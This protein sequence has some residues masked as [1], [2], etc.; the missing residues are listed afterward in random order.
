MY[1]VFI[2]VLACLMTGLAYLFMRRLSKDSQQKVQ[3]YIAQKLSDTDN[4][5][6][7][8]W[9]EVNEAQKR[10][11]EKQIIF[12]RKLRT[13]D[14]FLKKGLATEKRLQLEKTEWTKKKESENQALAEARRQLEEKILN[15]QEQSHDLE[16]SRKQIQDEE[17][18]LKQAE[19]LLAEK[20][21][22]L[23]SEIK[24]L[25]KD[26]R[27]TQEDSRKL[28][29]ERIYFQKQLK[30][31][32]AKSNHE[33][34]ENPE[35]EASV[36]GEKQ[37]N[38]SNKKA[39]QCSPKDTPYVSEPKSKTNPPK[40]PLIKRPPRRSPDPPEDRPKSIHEPKPEI[41]CQK[42]GGEWLVGVELPEDICTKSSMRLNQN[43][44]A[45]QQAENGD[46]FWYLRQADGQVVISWDEDGTNVKL[47]E[48]PYLF[49]KLSGQNQN[50][51]RLMR[52][53]SQGSYLLVVPESWRRNETLS[54]T[55][56]AEPEPVSLHGYQAHFFDIEKDSDIKIA[57]FTQNNEPVVI[58][59][60]A[61]DIE[62][63]GH[64]LKDAEEKRG[65]LFG[66]G[67]PV[68]R[69]LHEQVWKD[70]SIII[71]GEEGLG[72]GKG[73]TEMKPIPEKQEQELPLQLSPKK[74]GWYFLRFYDKSHELI[75]SMDFRFVRELHEIKVHQSSPVPLNYEYKPTTI[76]FSHEN[77]CVIKPNDTDKKNIAI[78]RNDTKTIVTIPAE[79]NWDKTR[80]LVCSK[81]KSKVPVTIL[82]ER[83]WWAISDE[84]SEP[85]EWSCKLLEIAR[86]DLAASSRKALWLRLPNT[87]WVKS[88][89]AGFEHTKAKQFPVKVAEQTVAMPFR[90]FSD[91]EELQS[92]GVKPF[93]VWFDHK[94]SE[95]T[96][97][98]A[99]LEV[100]LKCN[101]CDFLKENEEDF[102]DHVKSKHLDELIRPLSYEEMRSHF[103]TI[104]SGI[105]K[106]EY[107]LFYTES[108]DPNNPTSTVINHILVDCPEVPR[109]DGPVPISFS[110][111]YDVEEIKQNVKNKFIQEMQLYY[112]CTLCEDDLKNASKALRM[113]H[114]KNIHL[115]SLWDLH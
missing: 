58:S 109:G 54:G 55:A 34:P 112:K 19:R 23:M 33:P 29:E 9:R 59:P 86:N 37:K 13:L 50:Y 8:K 60:K 104:P 39:S 24:R 3:N 16:K 81:G 72:R 25:E 2:V 21:L 96:L 68:I 28:K 106:C 83:L 77:G 49:F 12:A 46:N 101:Y 80:W 85:S 110:P 69:A 41:V 38:S 113:E 67:L 61:I 114:L 22:K 89:R 105:Y 31:L 15:V 78:E 73:R 92:V 84:D 91:S 20:D 65:P 99:Q 87:R 88:V 52:Y 7:R 79:S 74:N 5:I 107:C 75:D 1:P 45:L 6:D 64:K 44:S 11:D 90:D 103:P 51:G 4:L 10:V 32:E 35:V 42:K 93:H 27:N 71:V 98:S 53:P 43:A 97:L 62:L 66:K 14:E 48:E 70:I 17:N 40:L 63:V 108:D 115:K 56:F 36:L 102:L 82:V 94:G 111:I 18:R 47:G 26:I 30:L 57:L 76:E 100:N 95:Y